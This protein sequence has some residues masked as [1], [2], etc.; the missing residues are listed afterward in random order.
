M[1]AST[2]Q[3]QPAAKRSL[4]DAIVSGLDRIGFTPLGALLIL[5]LAISP[6]LPVFRQEHYIRWLI[7]GA[8]LAAQ[9]VAF[10]FTAGYINVVNFGFAA[11]VGLGAYTSA[12]LAN[13]SPVIVIQTGI[14]PWIGMF[15]GAAVAGLVGLGLGVLTLRLRGIYAAVMAWFV[16]LA[17]LGLARNLVPSPAARSA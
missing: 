12:I 2:T 16:G 14:S 10:D 5:L 3:P 6:Y 9:A 7:M 17:L 13:N 4:W 15:A 11:I 8:F 1:T